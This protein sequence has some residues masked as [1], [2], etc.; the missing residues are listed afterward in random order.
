MPY[1]VNVF[2]KLAYLQV[3]L[4][5]EFITLL[6]ANY[7]TTNVAQKLLDVWLAQV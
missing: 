3:D 5:V 7:Q 2:S 6:N 4:F 1:F